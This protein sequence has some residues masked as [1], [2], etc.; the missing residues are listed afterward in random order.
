MK[1][2]IP[3]L[4]AVIVLL[5]ACKK[6]SMEK[7]A[8]LLAE[9][10]SQCFNIIDL[11]DPATMDNSDFE[12][13]LT[14]LESLEAKYDSIYKEE[15]QSKAFGKLYIEELKKT[16]MPPEATHRSSATLMKT[17]SFPITTVSSKG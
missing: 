4:L 1:R 5:P 15:E 8:R 10:T 16:D 7:D 14:E 12:S 17:K 2:L 6:H 11:N 13:C 3:I 9:K